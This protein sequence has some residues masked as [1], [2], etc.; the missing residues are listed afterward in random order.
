[1][2]IYHLLQS[3]CGTLEKLEIPYMV[4]GSLVLNTY[5]VSRMTRDIDIVIHLQM[6]DIARFSAE[7]A[8]ERYHCDPLSI[9]D[10]IRHKSMFNVIDTTS[11]Y[12]IDFIIRKNTP[13]RLA[14]FERKIRNNSLGIEA[15][16]VSLEDLILSKLI[17]IQE[18]Q[19]DRQM[20]DIRNLLKNPDTDHTYLQYWIKNLNLNTFNLL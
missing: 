16:I 1:M 9:A 10:S 19:S 5:A 2:T 11:G 15:W 3:V 13:Y 14:E 4:S 8:D 12:K 6:E 20:D 17:W 18:L 7:F